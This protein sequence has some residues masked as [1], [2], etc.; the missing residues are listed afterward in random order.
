MPTKNQ[1]LI[2]KMENA[3]AQLDAAFARAAPQQEI[4]PTWK[5]K[6][7]MDHI[8]G[9][10]ELMVQTLQ[11]YARGETPARSVEN[12]IDHFNAES[13]TARQAVPLEESRQAYHSLRKQVLDLIRAMPEGKL[14]ERY[15]APWGGM[16]TVTSV[17]KIFT[18]HE[19]EHARHIEKALANSTKV[20]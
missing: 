3:R 11:A 9:W 12:G 14:T 4:Y 17:V 6:Q 19:L 7:V 15:P 13:V 18:G 1:A 5:V 16:C 10:D 20:A 2:S 8:T